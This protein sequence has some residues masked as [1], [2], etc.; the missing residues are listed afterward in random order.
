MHGQSHIKLEPVSVPTTYDL[1]AQLAEN[2]SK[3]CRSICMLVN[4]KEAHNY[5]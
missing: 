3:I 5:M 1:A 4:A 2:C